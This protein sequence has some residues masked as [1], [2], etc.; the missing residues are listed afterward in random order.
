MTKNLAYGKTD[1]LK[2]HLFAGHKITGLEAVSIFGVQS[3]TKTISKLRED[4]FHIKSHR[5]PMI[6]S[7][8]RLN[9]YCNFV[10]PKN[11]P[12]KEILVSEYWLIK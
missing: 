8:V 10:P 1:A 4:G 3:L 6:R 11:L 5:I 9:K 7:V 12:T 2:E